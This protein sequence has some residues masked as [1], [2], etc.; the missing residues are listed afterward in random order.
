M[1]SAQ[2]KSKFRLTSAPR[3]ELPEFTR[4]FLRHPESDV[5]T[6]MLP[7]G[8]MSGTKKSVMLSTMIFGT[9]AGCDIGPYSSPVPLVYASQ[10]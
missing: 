8:F 4:R 2:R 3:Q 10:S 1:P 5:W 7:S 6:Q 9:I